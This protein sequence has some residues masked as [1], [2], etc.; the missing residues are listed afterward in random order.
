MRSDVFTAVTMKN[1][2]FWVCW[3]VTIWSKV[4]EKHVTSMFRIADKTSSF[5]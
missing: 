1:A 2:A 5:L 4:S 3:Y